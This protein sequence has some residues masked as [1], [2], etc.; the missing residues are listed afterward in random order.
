MGRWSA[1]AANVEQR[2]TLAFRRPFASTAVDRLLSAGTYRVVVDEEELPGLSFLAFRRTATMLHIPA[3]SAPGG[4]NQ[5]FVVDADELDAAF[6]A[7]H[8]EGAS[9][10]K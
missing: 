4:P 3:L 9:P 8:R 7:D 10:P 1:A 5:V 2:A 6:A